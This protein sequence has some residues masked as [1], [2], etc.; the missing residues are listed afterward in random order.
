[1]SLATSTRCL[2][3][4][5]SVLLLASCGSD[6]RRGQD[7][8]F[9]QLVTSRLSTG[10]ASK[11]V[12]PVTLTRAQLDTIITPVQLAKLEKLG[13]E[14]LIA[15]IG[16]NRGIETWSSVDTKTLSFRDGVLIATR[17]FSGDLMTAEAPSRAQLADTSQDYLRHYIFL[18]GENQ[19]LR[20]NFTCVVVD[21][22]PETITIVERAYQTTWLR[23]NCTG[24]TGSFDNDYW[25]DAS[26]TLRQ[27]RQWA[28]STLG[29]VMIKHLAK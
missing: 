28:G 5:A 26:G 4:A 19:E 17:G 11:D 14:G 7:G 13:V 10:F 3:L 8:G 24:R 12:A 25:Y 1:M 29:H 16:T 18:S 15:Q 20:R 2:L 9:A 6:P 21:F 23:E 27:S 22:G